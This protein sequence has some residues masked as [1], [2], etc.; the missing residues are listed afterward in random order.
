MRSARGNLPLLLLWAVVAGCEGISDDLFPSGA[1]NRPAVE[2]GTV[3]PEVGQTAPDFT[4]PDT[5]GGD[6]TLSEE[7]PAAR[8][9]VVYFTM[10]CPTCDSH[11]SHM[12]DTLMPGYPDVTFLA[13]DYVSGSVAD[14]RSAQDSH[15]FGG[16][17]FR[18]VADLSGE[19][20][21]LY[22][23]TMGT[24]VV[25]DAGGVVR[26]NEDYKDGS[27]VDDVLAGLE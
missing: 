8:A 15:G 26:L 14:A 10:W 11:M 18:V 2:A 9:V 4:V 6:F 13:V 25:I 17:D 1:D 5:L 3:G 7:L 21:A 19:V 23:G 22:E 20:E 24:A 27:R 16:P 12:R